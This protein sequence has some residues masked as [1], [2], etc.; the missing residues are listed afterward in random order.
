MT[1]KGTHF[2]EKAWVDFELGNVAAD[3][4]AKMQAHLDTGC[5]VCSQTHKLWEVVA[6]L[7]ARESRYEPPDHVIATA[8]AVFPLAWRVSQLPEIAHLAQLTFDSSHETPAPGFRGRGLAARHLLYETEG[9]LIDLHIERE[10]KEGLLALTGQIVRKD[11][12]TPDISEAQ[13]VITGDDGRPLGHATSSELGEFQLELEEPKT[14]ALYLQ[15]IGLGVVS[16]V[17]PRLD[18]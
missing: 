3:Q 18:D 5:A 17:L 15:L 10:P 12:G 1:E 14:A 13:I 7:A 11:G 8:K 9:L 6:E 4:A 2:Q 16:L